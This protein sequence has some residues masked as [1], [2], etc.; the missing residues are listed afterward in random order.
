VV[1]R[2]K[3][4]G[5]FYFDFLEAAV[6][7]DV[8][9][10]LPAQA[11]I[12][13]AL[14]YSTDHSYKLPPARILWAMDRLGFTGPM[15]EYIGVFW[16]NQR[17]RTGAIIPSASV[18]FS[19]AF[20]PGDAI[21]IDIGGQVFGKS[22]FPDEGLTTFAT[23]FAYSINAASVGVFAQVAGTVLTLT[24]R[25]PEPAY[26]FSLSASVVPAG[27]SAGAVEVTGSLA[28]GVSGAWAIDAATLPV[29]NRGARA[30]HADLFGECATRSREL[31]VASSMELVNPPASFAARF[32]GGEPVVTAIAFGNLNSTHCAFSTPMLEYH[33]KLYLELA[34]MMT[35]AGL[36]PTLQMG[37]FV[38]WFFT[39]W[40]L[41][42]PSGGMGF[43]DSETA[44]AALTALGRP[45]HRFLTPSD[46]PG[47]NGGADA[48]FLRNRLRD[49]SA[50]LAAHVRTAYPA[51][52]FEVLFPYDVN[53]PVPAGVNNL[54]GALNRY[55]NLPV[56]WESSA[57]AGFDRLKIEALDFG[58]WSRD[59]T[60][61]E[62]AIDFGLSLNWPK[63]AMRYLVPIFRA[64]S[65]WRKEL[66]MAESKGYPVLNLWAWDQM[67]LL[68]HDPT[69]AENRG[70]A[71]VS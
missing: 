20:V 15:N 10:P 39:N 14:D 28:G 36:T 1:I 65:A 60:L 7:G 19:G 59:L 4:A 34:A 40:S 13:P 2:L 11:N 56:E 68:A 31:V 21:F 38:W 53:H 55:V 27:G 62:A 25:S 48:L 29:M 18:T 32:P 6:P 47:V 16:W 43:Y 22:V 9:D 71:T 12:S 37:E 17:V 35:S 41:S 52:K 51:G 30:W 49:Y 42:N 64:A 46:S 33:K 3:S 66:L 61:A 24:A 26:G 57:T 70:R 44:T 54:G 50:A 58:A 69:R 5:F 45:L 23:H 8:P 67:C 63:S